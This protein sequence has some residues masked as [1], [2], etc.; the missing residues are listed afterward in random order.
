MATCNRFITAQ[1][2]QDQAESYQNSIKTKPIIMH[3]EFSFAS[4]DEV[5]VFTPLSTQIQIQ[6]TFRFPTVWLIIK[7]RGASLPTSHF[8]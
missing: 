7:A 5:I 1:N 6:S 8:H 4:S 3:Y 2:V